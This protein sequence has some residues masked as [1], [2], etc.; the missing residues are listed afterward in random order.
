MRKDGAQVS[1][2][3]QID[4][5]TI[6][7]DRHIRINQIFQTA[8]PGQLPE[9]PQGMEMLTDLIEHV[10]ERQCGGKGFCKQTDSL[11][12]WS[13]NHCLLGGEA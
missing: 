1:Q 13:M 12:N 6:H 5:E 10:I 2:Q 9:P 8:V 4:L 7:L 3:F 11:P